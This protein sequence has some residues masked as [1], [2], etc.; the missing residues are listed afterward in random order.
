MLATYL[1][2]SEFSYES[3]L[4]FTEWHSA[5]GQAPVLLSG[6]CSSPTWGPLW[7]LPSSCASLCSSPLS[8]LFSSSTQPG[9][10]WMEQQAH[11]DWQVAGVCGSAGEISAAA[12]S[13]EPWPGCFLT[14]STYPQEKRS[15]LIHSLASSSFRGGCKRLG[16]RRQV[17]VWGGG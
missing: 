8:D 16:C 12:T 5:H 6:P 4:L 11:G 2:R 7:F 1:S 14:I 13:W 10:G 3:D 17:C 9:S 15:D